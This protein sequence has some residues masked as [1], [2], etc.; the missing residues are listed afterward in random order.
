[1]K[2]TLFF[3]AL[4]VS[5]TGL[6][7]ATELQFATEQAISAT[8]IATLQ[9]T[10]TQGLF[11]SYSHRAAPTSA[12][13]AIDHHSIYGSAPLYGEYNDDG[14]IGRSGGD[15][16]RPLS[17]IW[18]DWQHSY[19]DIIAS[20][21]DRFNSRHDIITAGIYGNQ[22]TTNN[23]HYNWNF[24][25]GY[26]NGTLENP[27]LTSKEH[28][29]FIGLHNKLHTHNFIINSTI[30]T[31]SLK[32]T[33]DY[34]TLSDDHTNVWFGIA[35]DI[36]YELELDNTFKIYPNLYIGYTWTK[37][38]T[39]NELYSENL[40]NHTFGFFEISPALSAVKHIGSNWFGTLNIKYVNVLNADKNIKINDTT[41]ELPTING[42]TEYGLALEKHT[43]N[44]VF[45]AN[46]NRHDGD[47]SGWA[48]GLNIKYIF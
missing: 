14:T 3:S 28:G 32:S 33:T 11:S 9:H 4:L 43:E 38:Q 46:I 8:S 18:L 15:S 30:N 36:A 37:N 2:K 48:G 35:G 20:D 13:P 40:K 7:S 27:T 44:F 24:Y 29:G 21:F 41:F 19:D 31:G 39:Q 34:A 45:R 22:I 10:I 17:N 42:Y 5:Y 16:G 26:I 23:G 47:L 25:G 12:I 6:A 1:M